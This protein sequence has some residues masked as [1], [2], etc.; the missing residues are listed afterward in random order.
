MYFATSAAKHLSSAPAIST[1][2][3][4]P[5]VHI[6]SNAR[7]TLFCA[8][9]GDAISVWRVRPAVVL[10]HL[11]RTPVSVVTHG[12]N[13]VAN[14]S[15]D[16]NRIVVQTST[17]HLVLIAVLYPTSSYAPYA[18]PPM[19]ASAQ[20]HFLPGAGEGHLLPSVSLRFEG[21]VRIEGNI[22]CVSPRQTHIMFSTEMPTAVQRIP[23]PA[24]VTKPQSTRESKSEG[25]EPGHDNWIGHDTWF[26]NRLELPWLV[27]DSVTVTHITH[28]RT[29]GSEVWITSDGRAYFV[30]LCGIDTDDGDRDDNAPGTVTASLAA[31]ERA[32]S[33]SGSDNLNDRREHNYQYQE[34]SPGFPTPE[35]SWEGTCIHGIP[36]FDLYVYPSEDGIERTPPARRTSAASAESPKDAEDHYGIQGPIPNLDLHA[37]LSTTEDNDDESVEDERLESATVPL[38]DSAEHATSAA[39]NSKFSVV[40]VGARS[41][42]IHIY[43]FPLSVSTP[44]PPHNPHQTLSL[45]AHWTNTGSVQTMEWTSDGYALAV[46]WEKGWSVWSVGGRCLCWAVGVEGG[47]SSARFDDKFMFGVSSLLWMPGNL[48]LLVLSG[49]DLSSKADTTGPDVG[50]ELFAI[51]FAKSAITGQQAPDNTRYAFLQ[52]DD[53]VLVYRGADQPDMSV[54]NP[55]SDVWQHIKIPLAYMSTNWPTRYACISADG[56]LI[57]IAGRRG[58]LHYSTASGR[59]KMFQDEGQEQAFVVRGGMV[60]FHHVL[61][62]GVEASRS[63]QVRLYSRDLELS[64]MNVLH[65]EMFPA[66]I[67]LL[68]LIDNSLLV[69]TA[70]NTLYHYLIMPTEDSIK[71][72]LCGSISFEGVVAVPNLVRGMSWMVP[73]GQKQLGDPVDD[74]V[75]ATILLL[76]GGKLV[77]LRPRRAG[78]HEVKYDMQILADRI[79]FCWIHLRGIGTLENSL[80]GYDGKGIR[81]WLDAL[82]IE[83][84]VGVGDE[85]GRDDVVLYESVKE[86]VNIPLDFYPLSVLMDK[87]IIIGVEHE[88]LTKSSLPFAMFKIVTSTHLFLHH[89]LRY[90]LGRSQVKEAVLFASHYQ[91]LVYFSH[92]LEILL[93]TV[94]EAEADMESIIGDDS[95]SDSATIGTLPQVIEFL[96]HFDASLEVVVGCARKTEMARW[97]RL[98]DIVGSPQMLFE[99]CL[100]TNLLKTAGSYL[101]VLHNLEEEQEPEAHGTHENAVR[102]LRKA[103]A[104]QDWVL[105]QEVTRFLHSIDDSGAALRHALGEAGLMPIAQKQQQLH[106]GQ[107]PRPSWKKG[108]KGDDLAATQFASPPK[109]RKPTTDPPNARRVVSTPN[110]K[111]NSQKADSSPKG[112]AC[113]SPDPFGS[114]ERPQSGRVDGPARHKKSGKCL[115]PPSSPAL[116]SPSREDHPAI[117]IEDS[118]QDSPV[119]PAKARSKPRPGNNGMAINPTPRSASSPQPSS[120]RG[121]TDGAKSSKKK[122]IILAPFPVA[123]P[124]PGAADESPINI[125]GDEDEDEVSHMGGFPMQLTPTRSPKSSVPF[126]GLIA[127]ASNVGAERAQPEPFPMS[128][129]QLQ[130]YAPYE[131]GSPGE[132]SYNEFRAPLSEASSDDDQPSSLPSSSS[133]KRETKSDD[134][135]HPAKRRK[136]DPDIDRLSISLSRQS[137]ETHPQ[138]TPSPPPTSFR[139]C[140][141]CDEPFPRKPSRYLN[142]VFQSLLSKSWPAP[143]PSNPEGR[144]APLAVSIN[145]CTTHR[146]ESAII[147]E[148]LKRGWPLRIN[149]TEVK[150]RIE[151]DKIKRRLKAILADNVKSAHGGERGMFWDV[152]KKDLE[153]R[154]ARAANSVQGQMGTFEMTQPGYYGEKGFFVISST[155]QEIFPLDAIDPDLTYPL[156]PSDFLRRVLLPETAVLLI[157]EDQKIEREEA[158]LVLRESRA[159]GLATFP[160]RDAETDGGNASFDRTPSSMV[161]KPVSKGKGKQRAQVQDMEDGD[162]EPTS[163]TVSPIL[164]RTKGKPSSKG[165]GQLKP[166]RRASSSWILDSDDAPPKPTNGIVKTTKAAA[167]PSEPKVVAVTEK[168]KTKLKKDAE[169]KAKTNVFDESSDGT[170]VPTRKTK[171]KAKE[172]LVVKALPSPFR[173][174]VPTHQVVNIPRRSVREG[175]KNIKKAKG[176]PPSSLVVETDEEDYLQ[177][178]VIP[179]HKIKKVAATP[180]ASTSTIKGSSSPERVSPNSIDGGKE[181]DVRDIIKEIVSSPSTQR[182]RHKGGKVRKGA[183]DGENLEEL[184]ELTTNWSREP[185]TGITKQKRVAL[186]A[187]MRAK[188]EAKHAAVAEKKACGAGR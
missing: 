3:S 21:V 19:P 27:E 55:E 102:L 92:A 77:L 172:Q 141:F 152:A 136:L 162:N 119:K 115:Y 71:L 149:F 169:T 122:T 66:S 12:L 96:D 170:D 120:P 129:S 112:D 127:G 116:S 44:A 32:S 140:P 46:G 177:P 154:G 118:E 174:C 117:V 124:G 1:A 94:V 62:A 75:S 167:K 107:Q 153:V 173:L 65:R 182:A 93:H 165:N 150:R 83:P 14:W 114:W 76:V 82:T 74:M 59:W 16:G 51:P 78:A 137:Y 128:A 103:A 161:M 164:G 86:S 138:H 25:D 106:S 146:A 70:D 179:S 40:A 35:M 81:V 168:P 130:S 8:I 28:S 10:A 15:P 41:G 6:A 101:L 158:L 42:A 109:P 111:N 68:S 85:Q 39:I 125:S 175:T 91:H 69:Y 151:G 180:A 181:N 99:T 58:L 11:A 113:G 135:D 121:Q 132:S 166:E 45:P 79:E 89:M 159:F 34:P 36:P 17:S 145:L 144:D 2:G 48:E 87:G 38:L 156:E 155:L 67:V 43:P 176:V 110:A 134:D 47:A 63:H 157:Q 84:Q 185:V 53:G 90:H 187:K 56:R 61:I 142:S 188:T 20:R 123:L 60:W 5:L 72:H 33:A 171:Q 104:G 98:F 54:I 178:V 143:R 37:P 139:F 52:M 163:W 29:I 73:T 22:L 26:L 7:K 49:N 9:S 148:G 97:K 147:P 31:S 13:R 105:C 23:W 108:S 4:S 64:N 50:G 100:S 183:D 186:L 18:A 184:E 160:V 30:Q 80:W 24:D 95:D 88:A 126:S 57:A 131:N 133:S